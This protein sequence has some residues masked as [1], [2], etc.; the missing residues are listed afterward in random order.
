VP[1]PAPTLL[2]VDNDVDFRDGLCS[3][4][5]D[6]GYG[7]LTA[8]DGDEAL[9]LLAQDERVAAVLLDWW[10]DGMSGE[11]FLER[12][13]QSNRWADLPV[14]VLSG[15][16]EVNFPGATTALSKPFEVRE[17]LACVR[18]LLAAAEAPRLSA[19]S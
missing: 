19:G 9:D 7:V 17:L 5:E 6:E 3:L 15:S 12:L 13:R 18:G 4:L 8:A 1:R 2:L 14:A 11:E 10:M 16:P